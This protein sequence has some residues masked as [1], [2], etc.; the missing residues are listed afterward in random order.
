MSSSS[1]DELRIL[2]VRAV[3]ALAELNLVRLAEKDPDELTKLVR[4]IIG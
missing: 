1:E 2:E 3:L 4:E